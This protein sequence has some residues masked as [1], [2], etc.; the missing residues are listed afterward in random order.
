MTRYA[1]RSYRVYRWAS[2]PL[3]GLVLRRVREWHVAKGEGAEPVA[4]G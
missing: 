3:S 1:D 2:D 4:G